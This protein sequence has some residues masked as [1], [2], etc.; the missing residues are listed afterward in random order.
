[1]NLF[2]GIGLWDILLIFVVAVQGT[3]AAYIP[4]AR[5]KAFLLVLPIP[6]TLAV[7]AL[8]QPINVTHVSGLVILLAYSYAVKL[9]HD[10]YRFP[11][12]CSITLAALGY[13]VMGYFLAMIIPKT[14]TAF[15]VAA[16][17]ICVLAA[18]LHYALLHPI[19]K[20]QYSPLPVWKKFTAIV[21]IL[22]ILVLIKS[23]LQGFMTVFP[24]L[25]V[26][27]AYESRLSLYTVYRHI[28][29]ALL[30]LAP[31]MTTC[32]VLQ[33]RVGLAPALLASWVVYLIVLPCFI[34]PLWKKYD[35]ESKLIESNQKY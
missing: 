9:L 27:V 23:R 3:A 13:C 24:M 16:V 2:F 34:I 4:Q 5:L 32:Y 12:I 22:F 14:E 6:F 20:N 8:G 18:S 25:G 35:S 17:A 33:E 7:L 15:L 21:I 29:V 19:E 11:I 26:I 31:M 1:M 28:P 30:T 10:Q